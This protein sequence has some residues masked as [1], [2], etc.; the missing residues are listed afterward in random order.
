MEVISNAQNGEIMEFF[1]CIQNTLDGHIL[2]DIEVQPESKRSGITGFNKWRNRLSIAVTAQAKDGKANQAVMYVLS[3]I[4]ELEKSSIEI[5]SGHTSRMKKVKI[6]KK[7]S[8]QII[9]SIM[10]ELG[11]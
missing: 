2:I 8:K 1:S 9:D 7:D 3:K 6:I 10:A 4:F 5:V 11:E